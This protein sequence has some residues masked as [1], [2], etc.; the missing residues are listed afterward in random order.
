[1]PFPSLQFLE[2]AVAAKDRFQQEAYPDLVIDCG[3]D[4]SAI[5]GGNER[6]GIVRESPHRRWIKFQGRQKAGLG[7]DR[8]RQSLVL[9]S[10]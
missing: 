1:M 9:F 8:A 6:R 3:S 10:W 7:G 2:E 4:G 5:S